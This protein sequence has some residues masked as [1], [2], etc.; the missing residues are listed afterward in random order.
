M[1]IFN[2]Y[3]DIIRGVLVAGTVSPHESINDNRWA[4]PSE[5]AQN[6]V[7]KIPVVF[8]VVLGWQNIN[9]KLPSLRPAINCTRHFE[10]QIKDWNLR[11]CILIRLKIVC[12]PKSNGLRGCCHDMVILCL[13][14][15]MLWPGSLFKWSLQLVHQHVHILSY[16][17]AEKCRVEPVFLM[18]KF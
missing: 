9:L 4:G 6:A 14:I 2:S 15:E 7:I 12:A 5:P 3:F 10:V 17:A 16:F 18:D 1:A 13:S 8:N 11:N